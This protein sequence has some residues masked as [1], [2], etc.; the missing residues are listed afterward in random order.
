MRLM[1]VV[2]GC[3]VLSGCLS[4]TPLETGP[5]STVGASLATSANE[6]GKDR[7]V[8]DGS[9]RSLSSTTVAALPNYKMENACKGATEIEGSRGYNDCIEEETAAKAKLASNWQ[10]RSLTAREECASSQNG[11]LS[12]SYVEVMTCLQMKDWLKDSD[13]V[14]AVKGIGALAPA[15]HASLPGSEPSL[16]AQGPP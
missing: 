8:S 9:K 5:V 4:G 16:G 13:S 14:G 3:L 1:V 11:D 2:A 10:S 15:K 12:Q 6:G 7:R